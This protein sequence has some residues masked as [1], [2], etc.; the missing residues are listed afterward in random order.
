M[1]MR[2]FVVGDSADSPGRAERHGFEYVRN[3]TRSLSATLETKDGTVV[4]GQTTERHT[5][6]EFV[7]FLG[8]IVALQPL[9]REIHVTAG[10]LAGHQTPEVKAFLEENP[11]VSIHCTTTYSSWMNQ[12]ELWFSKT[13]RGHDRPAH[14]YLNKKPDRGDHELH[15]TLQ[16]VGKTFPMGLLGADKAH[17]LI[18]SRPSQSVY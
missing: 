10:N 6:D 17:P 16:R 13:E 8:R 5:S 9:G 18:A 1:L 14:L 12:V 11:K 2:G 7:A 4:V 3:G 15:Q